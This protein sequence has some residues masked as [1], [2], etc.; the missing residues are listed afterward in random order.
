[1][2]QIYQ[3]C[4]ELDKKLY[5]KWGQPPKVRVLARGYDLALI[6]GEDY[7]VSDMCIVSPI[8]KQLRKGEFDSY[9]ENT[10]GLSLY[11]VTGCVVVPKWTTL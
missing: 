10:S 5:I 1:M 3:N 7:A 8:F 6:L 11:I 4:I 2:T 9:I